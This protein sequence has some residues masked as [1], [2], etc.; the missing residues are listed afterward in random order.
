VNPE[1]DLEPEPDLEPYLE[2]NPEPNIKLNPAPD[3]DLV[4]VPDPKPDQL[5]HGFNLSKSGSGQKSSRSA[6]LVKKIYKL[7]IINLSQLHAMPHSG[8]STRIQKEG[9]IL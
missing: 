3:Q 9:G 4:V 8:K 5:V 7:H 2:P 6:T 1:L